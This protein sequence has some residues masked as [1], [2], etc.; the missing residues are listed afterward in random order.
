MSIVY[1]GECEESFS[2]L[3]GGLRSKGLIIRSRLF[4]GRNLVGGLDD[5]NGVSSVLQ[6]VTI[7]KGGRQRVVFTTTSGSLRAIFSYITAVTVEYGEDFISLGSHT[8]FPNGPYGHVVVGQMVDIVAVS[9]SLCAKIFRCVSGDF[10]I[11]DSNATTMVPNVRTNG[12]MVGFAW[13]FLVWVCHSTTIGSVRFGSMRWFCARVFFKEVNGT[14]RVKKDSNYRDTKAIVDSPRGPRAFLNDYTYR[15][16]SNAFHTIAANSKI[17]VRVEGV[18]GGAPLL[19]F[20]G[21]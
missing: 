15:I 18:R 13:W 5:A 19:L 9:R 11:F 16:Y 1:Q 4:Q 17:N 20:R 6:T 14:T 8:N 7:A 2:N 3:R 21:V 12:N 10:Y